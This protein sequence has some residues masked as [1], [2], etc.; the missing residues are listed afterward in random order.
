MALLEDPLRI[1]CASIVKNEADLL[2]SNI[3]YHR[4]IGMT[5]FI[6][7]LDHSTDET[8]NIISMMP[9]V[10]AFDDLTFQDVREDNLNKSELDLLRVQEYFATHLGIRQT[11]YANSALELCK[12]QGIDWLIFLDADELICLDTVHAGKDSLQGFLLEVADTVKAV[13]FRNLEVVPSR[14]SV[15]YAFQ[16]TLFKSY[17]IDSSTPNL[18]KS[19]A[20][21]PFTGGYIPAGWF[22][23]HSSGKLAI[24]ACEGSYFISPH[25]CHV[26]GELVTRE[27][28]LHY[29]IFSFQQ[30]LNKYRNFNNYP[31][32]QNARPLR[33]FLIDLV[34]NGGFS[35]EFLAAYYRQHIMYSED[36]LRQIH[37][38]AEQPID[39][40]HSVSNFFR[41]DR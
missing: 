16:D 10:Q 12:R 41:E 20:F 38:L 29:N 8:K 28:L 19:L 9:N 21:N 30:F 26:G 18:P 24:R 40:I 39:E 13:S 36:E 32:R 37:S 3:A 33:L 4:F 34:N 1:A 15:D 2:P 35:D 7:F 27:C 6:I 17:R 31:R 11:C 23:S 22:W 14:M 25:Q 5:D